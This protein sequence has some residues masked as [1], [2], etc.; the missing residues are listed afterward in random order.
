MGEFERAI[1]DGGN[2]AATPTPIPETR[3]AGAAIKI[4]GTAQ[5]DETL[6]DVD[7]ILEQHGR[8]KRRGRKPKESFTEAQTEPIE[9]EPEKTS[10]EK[11][12]PVLTSLYLQLLGMLAG[13]PPVS[14]EQQKEILEPTIVQCVDQYVPGEWGDHLPL[15]ALCVVSLD[16]Y[17]ATHAAAHKDTT[18]DDTPEKP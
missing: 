6:S 3:N 9:P 4:R 10:S 15:V 5:L 16:I 8:K 2:D 14:T 17:N 11:F 12:G 1:M 7:A 13:G 18:D